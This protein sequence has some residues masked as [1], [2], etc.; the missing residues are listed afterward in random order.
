MTYTR[1]QKKGIFTGSDFLLHR[2]RN[3][4]LVLGGLM[5]NVRN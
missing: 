5:P 3:D 1:K 2:V 4:D